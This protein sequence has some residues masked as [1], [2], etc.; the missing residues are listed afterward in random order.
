MATDAENI[1]AAISRIYAEIAAGA[2]KPSYSINGQSVDWPAYR[3]SLL[4]EVKVL[5]DQL[6]AAEGP[7]EEIT[8]GMP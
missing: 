3:R 4:E 6:G 2:L 8:Q 7:W 5:R 1:R